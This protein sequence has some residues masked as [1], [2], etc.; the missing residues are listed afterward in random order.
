MFESYWSSSLAVQGPGVSRAL[1]WK[2]KPFP[3]C[4]LLRGDGEHLVTI[5]HIQI[6]VELKMMIWVPHS[7]LFL[8]LITEGCIISPRREDYLLVFHPVILLVSVS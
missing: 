7:L 8:S 4:F 1:L 3:I 5:F 6:F 2:F